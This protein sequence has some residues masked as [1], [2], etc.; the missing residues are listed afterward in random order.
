M[1]VTVKELVLRSFTRPNVALYQREGDFYSATNF[2]PN[3]AGRGLR[4]APKWSA[5]IPF[6]AGF[7]NCRGAF[8]DR[9]HGQAGKLVFVGTNASNYLAVNAYDLHTNAFAATAAISNAVDTLGGVGGH[10]L[11]WWRS[12]LY[13]IA[14]TL[15]VYRSLNYAAAATEFH[16][17]QDGHILTLYGDRVM[18]A[19]NGGRLYIMN[20]TA[21]LETMWYSVT[22]LDIRYL[23]PFRAYLIAFN[24]GHDGHMH[25]LK[26]FANPTYAAYM[27]SALAGDPTLV[28][29]INPDL[30]EVALV[31]ASGSLPTIGSLFTIHNDDIYFC[32]GRARNRTLIYRFNGSQAD[33]VDEIPWALSTLNTEGLLTCEDQ[34]IYYALNHIVSYFKVWMGEGF[35]TWTDETFNVASD[36]TPIVAAL[37]PYV[38]V[39]CQDGTTPGFRYTTT[40][41]DPDAVL[42]TSHMDMGYPG[43]QKRLNRVT[44]LFNDAASVTAKCKVDYTLDQGA[45]WTQLQ[46]AASGA[47]RVEPTKPIHFYTL[48]LRLTFTDTGTHTANIAPEAISITYS[49]AD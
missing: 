32:P 44:V 22:G 27:A 19:D 3:W 8:F 36:F 34:M 20:H 11:L 42:V 46:A 39:V 21:Q 12:T 25:I 10:N 5:H 33:L 38:V 1:P 47:I 17:N 40:A 2:M 28:S 26:T 29:T 43:R 13:F 41:Y 16:P 49:I 15:K 48:Q 23:T 30:T 24:R 31:P 4:R 35:T 18:L 7:T 6:N 37:G 9:A 14:D 45:N